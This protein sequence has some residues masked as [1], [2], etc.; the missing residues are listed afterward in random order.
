MEIGSKIKNARNEAGYTQ[1]RAAEA[2]GVSRQTVSNWENGRSYP[3]IISVI[4]MSDLYSV[5][6]DH[7]LKEE[8]EVKE[9]YIEYLEESTNTV[10]SRDRLTGAVAAG[11]FTVIYTVTQLVFWI[12]AKGP[13]TAG[14]T[15]VFKY[16]LLPVSALI[17]SFLAGRRERWRDRRWGLPAVFALLF[18]LV[19]SVT[20]VSDASMAYMTFI[21]P[22]IK[23]APAG[24]IS[25]AAGL[26]AGKMI[27][28]K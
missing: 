23:Y 17:L 9:S 3:D 7:L 18:L 27:K 1:E 16:I 28:T 21:F 19:P 11:V 10:K 5:S 25:S 4:K 22:N 6:L 24:V 15:V 12:F 20:Y 2:L 8:N 14:C 26:L 13:E